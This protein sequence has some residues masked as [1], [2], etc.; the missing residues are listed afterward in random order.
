MADKMADRKA[1]YSVQLKAVPMA[2]LT[3][4][5]KVG[6]LAAMKAER[7]VVTKAAWKAGKTVAVRAGLWVATKAVPLETRMAANLAV[8]SVG[9]R[10]AV[11]SVEKKAGTKAGYSAGYWVVSLVVKMAAL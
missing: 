8:K 10:G 3:A 9:K 6:W 7:M 4:V 11:S 1:L 2:V 5:L